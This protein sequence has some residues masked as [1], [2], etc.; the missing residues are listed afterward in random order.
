MGL[1][2]LLALFLL[3]AG[4]TAAD[5]TGF[6]SIDCGLD[7]EDDTY[8][9]DLAGGI[10]YVADGVYVDGG[11]NSKVTTVYQKDWQ[12]PRYKTLYTLRSFPAATADGGGRNCYTLPTNDVG[13]KY[14]VRL[15]FLY[16]NYDNLDSASLRF[17]LTL[18]VNHWDTVNLDTGDDN[19]GYQAYAAVFVAWASWVPVCLVNIGQGTPFVSTVELRPLGDLPYPVMANQSLSLFERRS[20]RWSADDNIVRYPDDEYDRYWYAWE[21]EEDDD[22]S[23]ISTPSTI[24]PSSQFEVPSRVLETAFVP[25]AAGNSRELILHSKRAEVPP[26]DHLVILHFADFQNNKSRQFTAS[27]DDG[28]QSSPI[29][30]R[31]LDGSSITIWS[32]DAEGFSV[33]LTATAM[34]DLPP[35][36]NAYEVYGRIIH[37]N[38]MTSP[39][40]FDAIMAIKHEYGIK[41]NWIGDPCFPENFAWHGV[42]CS[43]VTD[44]KTMRI[45]SLDLSNSELHG[46]ISNNFTL[47]TALKYLNLSCNQLNGTV[48]DSLR[49]S[50]GSIIFS[51]ESDG[52]MCKKTITSSPS[53]N[54]K[55]K[56][57]ASVVAPVIVVAILVVAYLIWRTKRKPHHAT[58][59]STMVAQMMVAPPG[60]WTSHWDHLERPENRRFTYEELE[61]FTGNFKHLI[62]HGGFGNVYY[63]RLED[64]TEVAVKMRS[65]SSSHGLDEFLAEVQNLTKVYHRNLVFLLGY[66]WEKD[67]LALVYEYMCS[68]NLCDYLRGKSGIARTMKWATRVRVLLEAAQGLDYLHKGCTLP[69]IHGDV[70]T[71]NI[72]LDQNLKAKIADFGLSKTYHSD[73]QTHVSTTAAGSMGYIDPEYYVTGRLTEGSDIYSF[74]VV[75]LEV[76]TGE[77]PIIPGNDHII[78]R[79]MQKMV[80]GNISSVVDARLGDS[81]NVNSI[82]KVLDTAIM[83]TADIASQRPTMAT[84]VTQLKEGLALEEAHGDLGDMEN[85]A[86]DNI[87]SMS[88]LG[89]S[90]R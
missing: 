22:A 37:D 31:Y 44:D 15:E 33:K 52:D 63:G 73:S 72:L 58:D 76:T 87:S 59:D 60:H 6:L 20:M 88:M 62:G 86:R 75:L 64:N 89:P 14:N 56:L 49:K 36:L 82:W 17:N 42:G 7:D 26:R 54:G 18:G 71:H 9:D 77:P 46:L 1:L 5:Q 66:C 90:A 84:V 32:M 74:G 16:G 57:A 80:T 65:E 10:T 81:F 29:S 4:V 35:M 13:G 85:V 67:H 69:I 53:R 70:K 28:A 23:N 79:V 83:C 24:S 51:Y 50:N 27:I 11:N 47:L 43:K 3:E 39:Q 48:P 40:D 8:T 2:V 34:S 25:A 19:Y 41:K 38:P 61:K 12:G 78:Q 45:I 30:P 68:G 21:L 55:A